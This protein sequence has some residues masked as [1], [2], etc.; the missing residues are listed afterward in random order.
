MILRDKNGRTFRAGVVVQVPD[1]NQ[2]DSWI[3]PF[4]GT[5]HHQ[6]E[7]SMM[8]VIKDQDGC[9]WDVEASRLEILE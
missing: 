6:T 5:V 8:L 4:Q 9:C 1:P 7:C 3:Q 2:G